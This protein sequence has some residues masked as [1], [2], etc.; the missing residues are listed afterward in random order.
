MHTFRLEIDI[1][2]LCDAVSKSRTGILKLRDHWDFAYCYHKFSVAACRFYIY[3]FHKFRRGTDQ[4]SQMDYISGPERVP[5]STLNKSNTGA[6]E[7][8][9]LEYRKLNSGLKTDKGKRD[10]IFRTCAIIVGL[11]RAGCFAFCVSR[12]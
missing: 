11:M 8:K 4:R 6:F 1:T 2:L 3:C 5:K 9:R 7:I 10:L 12:M